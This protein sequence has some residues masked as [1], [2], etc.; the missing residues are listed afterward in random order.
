MVLHWLW[1][2]ASRSIFLRRSSSF[3]KSSAKT[4]SRSAVRFL[5]ILGILISGRLVVA[6]VLGA[7]E[8]Y[9][10]IEAGS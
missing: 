6:V 5:T 10:F 1:E 3:Q 9:S 7:N 8:L 4:F 2:A